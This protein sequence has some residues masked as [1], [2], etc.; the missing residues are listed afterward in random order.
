MSV[1]QT[2]EAAFESVGYPGDVNIIV[3]K[4]PICRQII[5]RFRG[6]TWREHTLE[7]LRKHQ[8]AISLFTPEAFQY[9]LPAFMINTLGA[10]TDTCLIPFLITKQFLPLRPEEPPARQQYHARRIEIF[11]RPQR[12]AIIAYLRE[13]AASGTALV[14]GDTTLAIARLE[15]PPPPLPP[16]PAATPPQH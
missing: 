14:A 6:A 4:C 10:W 2:I 12:S 16:V 8:L 15:E 5:D 3:C 9:F 1:R 11:S 7:T 13:Y